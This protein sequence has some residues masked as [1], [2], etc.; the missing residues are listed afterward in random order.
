MR[1]PLGFMRT[2]NLIAFFL[3]GRNYYGIEDDA[4]QCASKSKESCR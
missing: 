3:T 2:H 1:L 4:P